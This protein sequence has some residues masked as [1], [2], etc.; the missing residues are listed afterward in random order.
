MRNII[1]EPERW[2]PVAAHADVVVVGAGPAGFSAAIWAARQGAHTVLIEQ[3]GAPGGVATT[4]LMSHW[5]GNTQGGFYEEVLDRAGEPPA[6]RKAINPERLTVAILDMLAE[7]GVDLRLY[8][9]ACAPVMED[10]RITGVI[11]ESKTGRQAFLGSVIVDASGDGDIAA[12]AGAPFNKGRENDGR[13]QPMTLMFNVAGVDTERIP[14]L[15]GAFEDVTMVPAGNLQEIAREVLPA[16]AGH[17]LLYRSPLPGVITVNM[18]NVIDV[19]GTIAEDLT[20]A[21]SVCR[22]QMQEIE[23]FL[24]TYIPGFETC[25]IISSASQIGVRETRHFIGEYTLTAEDIAAARVFDDWVVTRAHF[26]FDIH[27]LD[28]AGLDKN[29]AQKHFSQPRGYTIP[30]RCLLPMDIDGL[31]L[32]GRNISGTH[33]AHSNFRVMPI[34]VNIGQAAGIAAALAARTGIDPR[35]VSARDVQQVLTENGVTA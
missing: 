10:K 7:A 16:P 28:G 20:R 9:F 18:T 8:T 12:H 26:N 19:D 13:M 23:I 5:T 31:L 34:C 11:T 21:E 24:Q 1:H 17:V 4:G 32:A 30:Y 22:H 14:H 15:P 25:Y 2:T 35:Q 33:K 27:N 29:G 6:T 3:A